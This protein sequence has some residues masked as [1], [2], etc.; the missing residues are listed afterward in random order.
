MAKVAVRFQQDREPYPGFGDKV[1]D[2]GKGWGWYEVTAV[3]DRDIKRNAIVAMQFGLA[4]QTLE[5][6]Q[7]I[8]VTGTRSIGG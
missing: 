4:R 5:I 2:I 8:V 1:L 7:A 3:A 6:G